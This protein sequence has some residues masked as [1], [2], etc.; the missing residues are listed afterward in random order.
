MDDIFS[1][2]LLWDNIEK[3]NI[4]T[5]KIGLIAESVKM[6]LNNDKIRNLNVLENKGEKIRCICREIASHMQ[7]NGKLSINVGELQQLV[8]QK[9][10]NLNNNDVNNLIICLS[11][12]FFSAVEHPFSDNLFTFKHR[13]YQEY[14]LYE[15]V[16]LEFENNPGIIRELNLLSNK[17]FMLNLFLPQII[18]DYKENQDILGLLSISF[19]WDYLGVSYWYKWNNKFL[20]TRKDWGSSD[21]EY[22]LSEELLYT[23]AAQTPP[24]LEMLLNDEN[25]PI[26]EYL[27]EKKRWLKALEIFHRFGHEKQANYFLD[28]ITN[29]MDKKEQEEKIWNNCFSFI[30][31]QY[32]ILG[33][34]FLDIMEKLPDISKDTTVNGYES[35]ES[36]LKSMIRDF[37]KIVLLFYPQFIADHF[38]KIPKHHLNILC[39][40]LCRS[41]N[42][43]LLLLDNG[44]KKGIKSLF[45]KKESMI[46]DVSVFVIQKLI[47]N[48]NDDDDKTIEIVENYFRTRN[49]GYIVDWDRRK[50]VNNLLAAVFKKQ[51]LVWYQEAKTQVKVLQITIKNFK[52]NQVI[53]IKDIIT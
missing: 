50:P 1:I 47:N 41:K 8:K 18:C 27:S 39:D 7:K 2:K 46:W 45:S 25:L 28:L 23:I 11:E 3:I 40:E 13:R 48:N 29:N 9:L 49:T 35:L 34:P 4:T 53:M 17:E 19:I 30:Y 33:I 52:D 15:K 5:T 43:L 20:P 21:P 16:K 26:S 22:K 44:I 37:Y 31:Y 51:D 6:L 38:E 32:K 12:I 10:A 36:P 24:S 14:F 42:L